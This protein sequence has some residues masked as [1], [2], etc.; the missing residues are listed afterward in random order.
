MALEADPDLKAA[1]SKLGQAYQEKH[2]YPKAVDWYHKAIAAEPEN[3]DAWLALGYLSQEIG[4]KKEAIGAF[5]K[6]LD[7]RP[8]AENKKEVADLIYY[9][10]G[11]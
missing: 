8:E 11:K 10:E 1:Y 9:L 4:K 6:F 5:K 2:Q 7:L 3:P